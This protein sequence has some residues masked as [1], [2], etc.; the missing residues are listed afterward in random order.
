MAEM[1]GILLPVTLDSG[2]QITIVPEKAVKES[3]FTG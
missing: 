2:A 1:S 3:E